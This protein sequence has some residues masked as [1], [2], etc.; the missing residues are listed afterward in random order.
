MTCEDEHIWEAITI[1]SDGG[2]VE[3]VCG[4]CE[5]HFIGRIVI[6][7]ESTWTNPYDRD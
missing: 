1:L 5:K 4:V 7:T 3:V 2:H 6:P